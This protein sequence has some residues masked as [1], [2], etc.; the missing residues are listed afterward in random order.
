[1]N[2]QEQKSAI[3]G[4]VKTL[5]YLERY[6]YSKYINANNILVDSLVEINIM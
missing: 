3:R 6:L 4:R 2:K 5:D 1:M